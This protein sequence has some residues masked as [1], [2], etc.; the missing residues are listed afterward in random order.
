MSLRN[1]IKI[2]AQRAKEA[3][4][5]LRLAKQDE[6]NRALHFMAEALIDKKKDILSANKKDVAAARAARKPEAFID[7]LLLTE[8]RLFDMS[9][10]IRDVISLPDP[11]GQIISAWIRP[12]GL[13][14]EKVRV[15][16]GVIG[17]IYESRPNVTAD[18]ASL[19]I[20]SGNSVILRGGSFA[21]NSNKAVFKALSHS[22]EKSSLPKDCLQMIFTTERKAIH[23]LL[24]QNEFIDLIIPRGSEALINE[25]TAQSQIPVIKHSKGLCHIYV[26][27]EVDLNMAE[28]IV[29]NA[30]VQRPGVC[31]AVETLLIHKDVAVRFLPH[32]F[33][34][35]K[36]SGVELRGCEITRK[37]LKEVKTATLKDWSTEYLSLILS[38]KIVESL[39]EAMGHIRKYSSGLSEAIITENYANALRFLNEVDSACVYVNA[40][41]RFTDGNQF[42]LG[43]EIGI[44]TDKIHARGPVGLKE[45]TTYKYVILGN[46]QIRIS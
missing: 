45:L 2:I 25:I 44:S 43:A 1:E 20:K 9:K 5:L 30:K 39:D 11:V 16:I 32:L 17:I 46:G 40:S 27:E 3:S 35:L 41:T 34:K 22:V 38:V 31:N 33:K 14:I 8:E 37:I 15:P 42:G 19:G 12:N 36:D 28:E 4:C 26:D 18:C 13:K 24:K 6:K 10:C 21:V 23:Y 7:R 29:Y